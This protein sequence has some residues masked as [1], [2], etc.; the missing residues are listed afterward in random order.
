[1][2][3][4]HLEIL[5]MSLY[6]AFP[7]VAFHLFNQPAYFERW[8]TNFKREMYP[9][10]KESDKILLKNTK[11]FLRQKEQETLAAAIKE[12]EMKNKQ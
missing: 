8:V 4:L 9:P 11:L 5:R 10:E 3:R 1:M 2:A 12:H 7:V 6:M